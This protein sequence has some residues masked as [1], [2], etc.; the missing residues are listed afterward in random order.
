MDQLKDILHKLTIWFDENRAN[1][2]LAD[3]H[4]DAKGDAD[5]AADT[6]DWSDADVV[7]VSRKGALCIRKLLFKNDAGS[8]LTDEE[9]E[10]LDSS[11][12]IENKYQTGLFKTRTATFNIRLDKLRDLCE[13]T[14]ATDGQ[15]IIL[16]GHVKQ[17][18]RDLKLAKSDASTRRVLDSLLD[19][20]GRRAAAVKP[21]LPSAWMS[22]ESSNANAGVATLMLS[23]LHWDEVVDARQVMNK[24]RY[25]REIA[26]KRL[27]R[28]FQKAGKLLLSHMS[29]ASY[30][31]LVIALGGDM[32]S[33]N[34]HE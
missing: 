30:D 23:D 21:K 11:G 31:A 20:M 34:I 32:V 3:E 15:I 9:F 5:D 1:I 33:G 29:G 19:V 13:Q 2:V 4:G 6:R 28:T 12:L 27:D 18:E 14:N 25:N 8:P 24:N 17:L 16:K 22:R 7:A 26:H 10:A